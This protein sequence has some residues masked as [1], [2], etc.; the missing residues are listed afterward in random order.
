[1]QLNNNLGE[2]GKLSGDVQD[3]VAFRINIQSQ[4]IVI[5]SLINLYEDPIGSIVREITSNCVDAHRERDLKMLNRRGLE[6]S[7][8]L[9]YFSTRNSVEIAYITSNPLIGIKDAIIFKDFGVGLSEERVKEIFTVFGSS[10]KRDDNIEIGGFGLGAK[11]VFAYTNTFFVETFHNG[12][13]R[14]YIL[15]RGADV[16]TMDLVFEGKTKE[17]NGTHVIVPLKR[18]EDRSKFLNAINN[19]LTYFPQ[20]VYTGFDGTGTIRTPTI[21]LETDDF[22][23]DKNTN[24]VGI[25]IGNVQYPVNQ[26]LLYEKAKVPNY[27]GL[28]YKF[29]IG[30]LDLVPSRETIRY[31]ENTIKLLVDKIQKVEAFAAAELQKDLDNE[32]NIVSFLFKVNM[33]FGR[34]RGAEFD[35]TVYN[36]PQKISLELFRAFVNIVN[37]STQ[38]SYKF[39][40]LTVT[41]NLLSSVYRSDAC[42]LSGLDLWTVYKSGD[43]VKKYIIDNLAALVNHPIYRCNG[44]FS[45]GKDLKLLDTVG[46][47]NVF[48]E[49]DSITA[50][51]LHDRVKLS[52]NEAEKFLKEHRKEVL[53]IKQY[54]LTDLDIK[55]YDAIVPDIPT[56]TSDA[57]DY[58]QLRKQQG[59]L[60]YRYYGG[61]G[62]SGWTN[63]EAKIDQIQFDSLIFGYDDDS[64]KLLLVRKIYECNRTA[65][66]N[67][68]KVAKTAAKYFTP[69]TY[70]DNFFKKDNPI[71]KHWYTMHTQIRPNWDKLWPMA[72]FGQLNKEMADLYL[73]LS[74]QIAAL[75]SWDSFSRDDVH[76]VLK[77]CK[78]K[79]TDLIDTA[80]LA[81]FVKIQ[82]YYEGLGLLNFITDLRSMNGSDFKNK[83]LPLAKEY[84]IL[85]NKKVD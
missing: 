52:E 67:I 40:D 8:D 35:N 20:I 66:A 41:E 5:D 58:R 55:D 26:S 51:Y 31:T 3:S 44:N 69:E 73:K 54:L 25:L 9:K 34:S 32:T 42:L 14:I 21:L 79:D 72:Y 1:M 83:F 38:S 80:L 74:K 23:I 71:I 75:H 10:T 13:Q 18:S 22:L 28:K 12:R 48:K 6:Q 47:F 7:D 56:T 11:S 57:I 36:K 16:P 43:K 27:V 85:K 76:S 64:E 2:T 77:L 37:H 33:F 17:L 46:T 53:L 50:A 82:E 81:D 29:P 61:T 62:R 59:K 39:R 24:D 60:F 4:S 49:V 15:S 45:R 30:V 70:V 63:A 68:W 84:L 78:C 19:Q 65:S